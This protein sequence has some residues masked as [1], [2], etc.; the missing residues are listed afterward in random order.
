MGF[1]AVKRRQAAVKL[2]TEYSVRDESGPPSPP[3]EMT[4]VSHH[5][6][7]RSFVVQEVRIHQQGQNQT[8]DPVQ[9]QTHAD[10]TLWA[11]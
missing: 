5:F 1:Q 9:V 10:Q 7:H 4:K 8:F 11:V 3:T 6:L 2:E